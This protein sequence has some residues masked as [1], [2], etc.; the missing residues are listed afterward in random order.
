MLLPRSQKENILPE[1]QQMKFCQ[2]ANFVEQVAIQRQRVMMQMVK[3]L[4]NGL[5]REKVIVGFGAASI[6]HGSR[7][8]RR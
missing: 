4:T 8:S 3:K 1:G 7:I 2:T 6:G 5:P